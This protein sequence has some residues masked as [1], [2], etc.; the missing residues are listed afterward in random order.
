MER[1]ELGIADLTGR[2]GGAPTLAGLESDRDLIASAIAAAQAGYDPLAK[3]ILGGLEF[4]PETTQRDLGGGLTLDTRYR[5]MLRESVFPGYADSG[6]QNLT[7]DE[8]G[9]FL[10][11]Q[12]KF[13]GPGA[14]AGAEDPQYQTFID[15]QRRYYGVGADGDA[16]QAGGGGMLDYMTLTGDQAEWDKWMESI[17]ASGIQ[18]E[19][20]YSGHPEVKALLDTLRGLGFNVEAGE[21]R[22]FETIARIAGLS[23]LTP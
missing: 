18:G 8:L 15:L 19:T 21:Q 4:T 13:Y 14:T 23:S 1:R 17:I 16:T 10:A 12:E 6:S 9:H 11:L 7:K 3:A 20:G 2:Y 5:D 22:P